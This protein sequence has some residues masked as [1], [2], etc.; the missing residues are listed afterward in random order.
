VT[1]VK[2]TAEIVLAALLISFSPFPAWADLLGDN[3]FQCWEHEPTPVPPKDIREQGCEDWAAHIISN[4][5]GYDRHSCVEAVHDVDAVEGGEECR[6]KLAAKC[7][8]MMR[9]ND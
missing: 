6:Q 8:R 4:A 5:L 9:G 3:R 1:L 2:I 7:R